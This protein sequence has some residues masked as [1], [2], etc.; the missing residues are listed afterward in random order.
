[1]N[2]CA[3]QSSIEESLHTKVEKS[4]FKKVVESC[5]SLE[6]QSNRLDARIDNLENL[7]S[8]LLQKLDQIENK[9][10]D[11]ALESE[12]FL[13]SE[14]FVQVM[15]SFRDEIERQNKIL[16]KKMDSDI[17]EAILSSKLDQS[18]IGPMLSEKCEGESFL[19]FQGEVRDVLSDHERR[20]SEMDLH[21]IYHPSSCENK[22]EGDEFSPS[23]RSSSS[24]TN[25]PLH[26]HSHYNNN[27]IST[28]YQSTQNPYY[29]TSTTSGKQNLDLKSQLNSAKEEALICNMGERLESL[30]EQF[31]AHSTS[32]Q[33]LITSCETQL[34]SLREVLE[35]ELPKIHQFSHNVAGKT[36][37]LELVLEGY[38]EKVSEIETSSNN[39]LELLRSEIEGDFD[40]INNQ[41][42]N[43]REKFQLMVEDS[44]HFREAILQLKREIDSNSLSSD[45]QIDHL[46]EI[47]IQDKN[48]RKKIFS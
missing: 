38:L 31:V 12:K 43:E 7:F 32:S 5:H 23:R 9:I 28:S 48:V 18:A 21:S 6:T 25:N 19:L 16:M 8:S 34:S 47:Q 35:K 20:L 33:D 27:N 14:Q 11:V 10:D 22:R 26:H 39:Q 37:Q 44:S 45:Q 42:Q 29:S 24:I 2:L 15:G 36:T 3:S 46:K 40:G 1:L 4:S 17:C 13:P 41:I 30:E